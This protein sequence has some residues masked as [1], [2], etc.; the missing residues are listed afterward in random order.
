M[1]RPSRDLSELRGDDITNLTRIIRTPELQLRQHTI[2]RKNIKSNNSYENGTHG[3]VRYSHPSTD[4]LCVQLENVAG[5][6]SAR[7]LGTV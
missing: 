3:F 7:P 5:E 4:E 6:Q 1:A 2:K